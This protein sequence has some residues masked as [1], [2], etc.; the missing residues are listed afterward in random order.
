VTITATVASA[1]PTPTG[2]VWF[3][4]GNTGIATVVLTNGVATVVK[5]NFAVG[6]H[7]LSAEYLGDA[8]FAQSTS[9]VLNQVVQSTH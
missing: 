3:K 4:D 2:K 7:P 8:A 6:T 5:S 1:G 9:S